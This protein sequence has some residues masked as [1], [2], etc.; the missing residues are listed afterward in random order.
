MSDVRV[1]P[2]PSAYPL[3]RP[4]DDPRFTVGLL[5]D[6][7]DVLVAHGYP[8]PAS[9]QDFITLQSAMFAFLYIPRE[10]K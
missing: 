1:G 9:G 10:I 7:A 3:P 6:L 2:K 5:A 8:R 4:A